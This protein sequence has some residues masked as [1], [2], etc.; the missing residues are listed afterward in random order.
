MRTPLLAD[1]NDQIN[2]TIESKGMGSEKW[3]M[4]LRMV[5]RHLAGQGTNPGFLD[6]K[7]SF[8][9]KTLTKE[10]LGEV[11]L[12]S[13]RGLHQDSRQNCY[14]SKY[15]MAPWDQI[16]D[17]CNMLALRDGEGAWICCWLPCCIAVCPCTLTVS[18]LYCLFGVGKDLHNFS[19]KGLTQLDDSKGIPMG[20]FSKKPNKGPERQI[21]QEKYP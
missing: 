5:G 16:I 21:M 15:F 9:V 4:L 14:T 13:W 7:E 17:P 19:K 20:L 12:V 1:Q 3:H 11:R 10:T 6:K 18:V 2:E 8:T